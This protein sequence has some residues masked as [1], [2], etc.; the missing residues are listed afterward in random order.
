MGMQGL[1]TIYFVFNPAD[2]THVQSYLHGT[3]SRAPNGFTHLQCSYLV[4]HILCSILESPTSQ[5][6]FE[7]KCVY[8]ACSDSTYAKK[9]CT[10]GSLFVLYHSVVLTDTQ[11]YVLTI[12]VSYR[13]ISPS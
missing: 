3:F 11:C 5:I 4:C 9:L 2:Y 6:I 1:C 7:K 13:M 12:A 10:L 8:S